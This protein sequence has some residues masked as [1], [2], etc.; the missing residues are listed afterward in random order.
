MATIRSVCTR[1]A[2]HGVDIVSEASDRIAAQIFLRRTAAS[3]QFKCPICDF[4]GR[5]MMFGNNRLHAMCP[6]C[7]ALE[8]HR[9]QIL[10]MREISRTREFSSLA[11][12]HIAP[13]QALESVFRASF[14]EYLTGDISRRA[15]DRKIDLTAIDLPDS[16]I[17]VLYA[18]HVLEHIT[19]DERAINEIYRI[20][21]PSGFAV[22]PVPI[23]CSKTV[24]YPAPVE[25]EEWHVR[26]PGPDYFERY[27]S[28]FP[29]VQ[30]WSSS[31][32]DE[33]YQTWVYEDRSIP[34]LNR[35]GE[36]YVTFG[37]RH[38]DLVPVCF[39]EAEVMC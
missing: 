22:L 2:A 29:R 25:A 36:L 6:R 30:V 5:F 7:K 27:E 37:A 20:L 3:R 26:A 23:I 31:D 8:R 38:V 12:L 13:E 19:E 34:T 17:D 28:V 16:S 9:L 14:G 21:R 33:R 15:V 18:S 24:E 11:M 39:R 35:P 10:V 4:E 1:A 32:F